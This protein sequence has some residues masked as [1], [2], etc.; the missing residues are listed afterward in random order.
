WSSLA[1]SVCSAV[2][3]LVL[4][5]RAAAH[6]V[7]VRPF[8]ASESSQLVELEVP[9]ERSAPMTSLIVKAPNG[10]V[11]HHTRQPKGWNGLAD[12][13][14]ASFTG[15]ALPGGKTATFGVY[16]KADVPPGTATLKA[17]QG[18]E[19]G[20]V[21]TWPVS[22]T[23]TPAA[24]TPS[25]NLELAAIVGLIGILVVAAIGMLAWRRRTTSAA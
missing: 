9:N 1:I 12:G 21:V 3:V 22:L 15:D 6:V 7:A 13:A 10:L 23:V 14:T 5:G 11:I 17:A 4:A 2:A 19:G 20:A 18:Y 24:Q 25:Q 16:I 8:I